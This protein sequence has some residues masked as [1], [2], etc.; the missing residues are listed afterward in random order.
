MSL[1]V[2]V[3]FAQGVVVA[4]DRASQYIRSS[5]KMFVAGGRLFSVTH[6]TDVVRGRDLQVVFSVADMILQSAPDRIEPVDVA[7]VA[8]AAALAAQ[9]KWPIVKPL[10]EAMV[11]FWFP[12]LLVSF[13]L[14]NRAGVVSA[15]NVTE[16]PIDPDRPRPHVLQG[17]VEYA[18]KHVLRP[19]R[20]SPA[21][22]AFIVARKPVRA[23]SLE[24][25]TA[26]ATD[27]QLVAERMMSIAPPSEGRIGDGI[28]MAIVTASG[29]ELTRDERASAPAPRAPVRQGACPCGAG[30][31]WSACHGS[32]V[33]A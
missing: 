26:F 33:P 30:K 25:A 27:I 10:Q 28:D 14:E 16:T 9:G 23:V 20:L 32:S 22:L 29:V 8:R 18:S 13:V 17:M 4:S 11:V 15:L 24:E 5:P 21:S 7:A 3:P 6:E 19:E 31:E 12:R 2:G 1:V